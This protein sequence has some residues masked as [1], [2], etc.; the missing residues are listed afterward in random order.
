MV[1]LYANVVRPEL[2]LGVAP[3]FDSA[4]VTTVGQGGRVCVTEG[5][6]YVDTL[7]WWKFR[8]DVGVEGWG[9]G[10]NVEKTDVSCSMASVAPTAQPS[11]KRTTVA[12]PDTGA[13]V[14]YLAGAGLIGIG[15]LILVG[16]IRRRSSAALPPPA[17]DDGNED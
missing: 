13:S 6:L 2:Y 11:T 7:W 17:D 1:G 10:D 3:G 8:T 16:A 4:H 12:L 15:V 5:P 14:S 9:V